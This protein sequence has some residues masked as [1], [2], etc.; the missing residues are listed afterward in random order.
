MALNP[1]SGQIE[2]YRAAFFGKPFDWTALG[3]SAVITFGIF[4]Y[5]AY[6]FRRMEKSFADVI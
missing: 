2:A 4:I 3:I 6:N 5:S 1:L